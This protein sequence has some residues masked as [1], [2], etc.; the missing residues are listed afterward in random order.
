MW[1][2]IALLIN[3]ITLK[4]DIIFLK[5]KSFR[6]YIMMEN[7][8]I[9]LRVLFLEEIACNYFRNIIGMQIHYYFV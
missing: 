9:D 8:K 2:V 7:F 6:E 5:R 1:L 3:L 4:V